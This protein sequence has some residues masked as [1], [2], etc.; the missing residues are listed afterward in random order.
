[1]RGRPAVSRAVWV[2]G[3]AVVLALSGMPAI[4]AVAAPREAD[5][6]KQMLDAQRRENEQRE[7]HL[8][9]MAQADRIAAEGARLAQA[10][11]KAAVKLHLTETRTQAVITQIDAKYK[12]RQEA[13]QRLAATVK[14]MQPL[15]PLIERLSM[16]PVETLL[17]VPASPETTLRGVLVLQTL[18]RQMEI[19]AEAVRRDQ[20]QLD[21]V[22]TALRQQAPLL[23]EAQ[24]T[25]KREADAL[26]RDIA[27]AH[28]AR[29]TV[30]AQARQAA[31]R[32]AAAAARADTLRSALAALE[33]ERHDAESHARDDAARAVRQH[34]AEDPPRPPAREA[35]P[36]HLANAGQITSSVTTRD[37]SSAA[38]RGQLQ[39]P[40]I[41]VAVKRWGDAA[42]GG[43]ATGISF[44]APPHARVISPC[45]GKVVFAEAFRSYGLLLI[46]DCGGGYH[47]VLSGLNRLDVKLGQP[48]I[49]GEPVGVMPSWEP[50]SSGPRPALYL[51]LR[52]DGQ[53]INPASWLRSRD[54]LGY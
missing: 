21:A 48:T 45:S 31:E 42:E 23:A 11:A 25:Q 37:Q 52:H 49:A 40:V 43:P 50:G 54:R 7:L 4:H 27:A 8:D 41:G 17:A 33:T 10:R 12:E 22:T 53:P 6:R 51:E 30:E 13:E 18:V 16:F 20:A 2:R 24:A 36:A 26:D 38:A 5:A 14:A 9:A 1:M 29:A 3:A 35:T 15:L 28:E 46:I 32:G 19:E 39:Q 47:V 34:R 44:Y